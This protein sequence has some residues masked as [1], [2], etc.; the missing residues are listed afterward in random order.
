M[1]TMKG[2]DH[3]MIHKKMLNGRQIA[4]LM[5]QHFRINDMENSMLEVSDLMALEL[6][7]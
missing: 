2:E 7:R 1:I 6:K 5:F 4:W 3:Q